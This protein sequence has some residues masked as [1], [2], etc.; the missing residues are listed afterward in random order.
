VWIQGTPECEL[1]AVRAIEKIVAES[2]IPGLTDRIKT[3]LNKEA[4]KN[5]KASTDTSDSNGI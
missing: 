1:V 4:P 3:F 2:H 5:V